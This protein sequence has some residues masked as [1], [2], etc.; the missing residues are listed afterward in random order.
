MTCKL[1]GSPRRFFPRISRAS[2]RKSNAVLKA[3]ADI[4]HFDVMD[5]HYVPNLTIGPLVCEALRKYGVTGAYRC[6]SDG[7]AGGSHR[8]GLRGGGRNLHPVSSGSDGAY[9]SHDR[10]HPRARLQAGVG[11]QSG[12]AARVS[13]LHAREDRHGAHHVGEPGIRRAEVHS[14]RHYGR[15]P[16]YGGGSTSPGAPCGSR[17]TAA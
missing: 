4:I 15:S 9:R 17:S 11:I 8:P 13:R 7:D 10:A 2:A 12:D 1:P 3:G 14:D 16:R 5:N 6:T